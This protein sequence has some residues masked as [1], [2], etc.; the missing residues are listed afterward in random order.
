MI[1]WVRVKGSKVTKAKGVKELLCL[2]G[3]ESRSLMEDRSAAKVMI[4]VTKLAI[5][6]VGR[7]VTLCA[8]RSDKKLGEVDEV[9]DGGRSRPSPGAEG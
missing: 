2:V 8:R 3:R 7:W 4:K 1:G 6:A 5:V 9:R